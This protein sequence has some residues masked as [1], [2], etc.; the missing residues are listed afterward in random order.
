MIPDFGVLTAPGKTYHQLAT[1]QAT[2]GWA[3]VVQRCA[4]GVLVLATVISLATTGTATLQTVASA[5][6]YWV[7]VPLIQLA[8]ALLLVIT[9]PQRRVS[10]A[11][12][13]ELMW[14]GHL[15]WTLWLLGVAIL[16]TLHAGIT[17][18]MAVTALVA[19]VWRGVIV[20]ALCREALGS[21]PRSAVIRA[22]LHQAAVLGIIAVYACWAVALEARF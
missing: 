18:V 7:M 9:A 12:G 1:D 13:V 22:V 20:C 3:A 2:H 10:T 8:L 11:R 5:A 19:S 17:L 16:L 4:A 14:V 21:S 15:P 6:S